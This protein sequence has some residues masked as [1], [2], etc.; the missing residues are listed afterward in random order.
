MILQ[1]KSKLPYWLLFVIYLMFNNLLFVLFTIG[2]SAVIDLIDFCKGDFYRSLVLLIITW[3][4]I[5]VCALPSLIPV[6]YFKLANNVTQIEINMNKRS[7]YVL[8]KTIFFKQKQ[9]KILVDDDDFT[10]DFKKESKPMLLQRMYAHTLGTSVVLFYKD[11]A[12]IT[13]RETA[14]WTNEQL[15][16][17]AST[18]QEIKTPVDFSKNHE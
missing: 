18:L 17:V 12:C 4:F 11:R 6:I 5:Y 13:I 8:Y 7:I 15:D 1:N 14:G 9:K 10:F 3:P 16:L 2:V